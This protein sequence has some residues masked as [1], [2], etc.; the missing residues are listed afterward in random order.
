MDKAVNLRRMK[1]VHIISGDR[2]A[3]AE[4]QAYTLLASLKKNH[5][6]YAIILNEGELAERLKSLQISV[7]IFDEN[8]LS[9]WQIF[10]R[11]RK[12]LIEIKPD[13]VHTHRQKENIFGSIANL[14]SI[15]VK[16][17]RTIH[18][19]SEFKVTGFAKFQSRLDVFCGRNFQQAIIAVSEDLHKKLILKFPQSKIYTV[20]NGIDP[21]EIRI[22]LKEP[23][24]K[25]AMPDR[26]HIG[27]VGRLDPVKRIDIFLEMAALL[28]KNH[29]KVP[30]HFH[31]FGEG[32]LDLKMKKM[33]VNLGIDLKV[34]FHGHRMDIKDCIF[35][36]DA[37]VI[38][39]DHEGLPMTALEAL[40]IGTPIVAHS[41]GGLTKLLAEQPDSL[42][43]HHSPQKFA[44]MV[45][46]NINKENKKIMYPEKYLLEHTIKSLNKIYDE[47]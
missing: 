37:I 12:S 1:I 20:V 41:V 21:G 23:D 33:A 11:I 35:G 13:V 28:L 31:V 5:D 32:K 24:Y 22:N 36:L 2:W 45:F 27:I 9:S 6:V 16:C 46:R 44:E 29:P 19:D 43:K 15:R 40:A 34:T 14:T 4:V 18:G 25:K 26:K 47:V 10:T 39:S 7:Y 17:V 8:K 38:C 42:I 3:G 30:W